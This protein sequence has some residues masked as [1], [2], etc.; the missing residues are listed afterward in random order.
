MR[1]LRVNKKYYSRA[2]RGAFDGKFPIKPDLNRS[3]DFKPQKHRLHL[4]KPWNCGSA[5]A[6]K[7]PYVHIQGLF[8]VVP[9][10]GE[11]PAQLY[12]YLCKMPSNRCQEVHLSTCHIVH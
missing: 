11:L 10:I 3:K 5:K 4:A 12:K 6:S 7:S 9:E 2:L 8:S 1:I